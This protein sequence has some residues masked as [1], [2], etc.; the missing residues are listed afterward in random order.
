MANAVKTFDGLVIASIKSINGIVAASIKSVNWT[1]FTSVAKAFQ[2]DTWGTLTTSLVSYWKME[3]STDYWW[4]NNGSDT[5]MSYSTWKVNNGWVFSWSWLINLWNWASLSFGNTI[6]VAF[7][8]KTST[9]NNWYTYSKWDGANWFLTSVGW[10]STWTNTFD[11]R[12]WT[13]AWL[14]GTSNVAD[15]T[16]RLLWFTYDGTTLKTYVNGTQEQSVTRSATINVSANLYFST[17][18]G[19]AG[20]WIGTFDECWVWSKILSAQEWT[21]LYNG[22]S[23]QTM[24]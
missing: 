6:S 18:N 21:D 14:N 19:S 15:W 23:W 11:I 7:W 24:V 17:R 1:T 13:D 20:P 5:S 16:F 9:T 8:A 2:V 3:D 12:L 4:T 22:W 10:I